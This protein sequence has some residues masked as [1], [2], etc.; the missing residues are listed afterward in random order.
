MNKRE[1]HQ[2]IKDMVRNEKIGRQM[3][4]Q[5]RLEQQGVLVT[6]TTLSRD[7]RELGLTKVYEG[8]QSF[9]VLPSDQDTLSLGQVLASSVTKVERASF[10][11][12]FHTELGESALLA[13]AIDAEKPENILGTIAGADTLLAICRDEASAMAVQ[14]D[15]ER[16]I[17]S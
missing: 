12:V 17:N 7:L 4:I 6:Q 11:L 1:R 16:H 3:D 10:I 8:N 13:N 14:E 5:Q 9:Y 15:I 2:L